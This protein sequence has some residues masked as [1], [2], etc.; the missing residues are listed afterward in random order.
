MSFTIDPLNLNVITS[1]HVVVIRRTRSFNA[2]QRYST[3]I[4]KSPVKQVVQ[5]HFLPSFVFSRQLLPLFTSDTYEQEN[6][7]SGQTLRRTVEHVFNKLTHIGESATPSITKWRGTR[8]SDKGTRLDHLRQDLICLHEIVEGA[9]RAL[10]MDLG[11]E[12]RANISLI[13]GAFSL[14]LWQ[15]PV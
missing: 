1:R 2:I 9:E 12:F 15:M 11:T 7:A 8:L 14:K 4:M 5:F 10:E 3:N 13:S 6:L